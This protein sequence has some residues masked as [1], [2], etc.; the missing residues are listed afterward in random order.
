MALTINASSLVIKRY[1]T[2]KD[3]G[4]VFMET[5]ALG[6]R[7]KFVW[8]QIDYVLMSPTNVLSFQVGQEVFSIPTKPGKPKH[9]MAIQ[10]LVDSV[11][12]TKLVDQR[13][14]GF[15]VQTKAF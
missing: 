14:V 4:V 6:G 15:P 12:R 10:Q 11:K 2:V 5:A 7:K 1:L 8:Q 3:W 9:Q 13:S